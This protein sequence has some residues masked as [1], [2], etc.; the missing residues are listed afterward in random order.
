MEE[1]GQTSPGI[2]FT[3][4]AIENIPSGWRVRETYVVH[5]PH[6]FEEVFERSE[7]G[8]PFEVYSRARLKRVK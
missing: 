7:P 1:P 5:G 4:E 2:V 6:E 8:K 3:T